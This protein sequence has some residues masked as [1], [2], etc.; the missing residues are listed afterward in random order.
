MNHIVGKIDHNTFVSRQAE[1]KLLKEE[2][3]KRKKKK[4]V[5]QEKKIC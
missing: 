4:Q 2:G 3:K 1:A 5:Q